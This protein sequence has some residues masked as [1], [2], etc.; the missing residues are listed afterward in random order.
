MIRV[1]NLPSAANTAAT[2]NE[3]GKGKE[4]VSV[5][6]C[7]SLW[8]GA[9]II[10]MRGGNYQLIPQGAIAVTGD[11][12]VWIGPHAELPPIHAARQ[13]VYEGGLITPGLIDCHTHLVFGDDRSNEF[14]QRLNG[15]SYAEIAANGGGIISTVRATRQASEQQLLEQALFRLK[16]LLAEGEIGRAHV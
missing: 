1:T 9:D 14:E 8:F 5:T 13:V 7:D 4:M 2:S 3:K 12:I 15:V 6:H 10:T 16:P 11:K